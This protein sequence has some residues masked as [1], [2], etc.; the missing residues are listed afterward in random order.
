MR[1]SLDAGGC[2]LGIGVHLLFERVHVGRFEFGLD[3]GLRQ[4]MAHRPQDRRGQH[5]CFQVDAFFLH[6]GQKSLQR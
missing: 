4:G 1:D 2:G 3:L 5:A 6:D